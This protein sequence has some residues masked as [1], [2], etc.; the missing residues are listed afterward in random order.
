IS[1]PFQND[2]RSANKQFIAPLP[3]PDASD[4]ERAE[5]ARLARALQQSWTRRRDLMDEAE[6]RLGVLARANHP[7]RWLWPELPELPEMIA[8]APKALK[9]REDR[10]QWAENQLDGL[11]AARIETLQAALASGRR[12]EVRFAGGEL[13]MLADGAPLLRNIFL[14]EDAGRLT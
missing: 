10:R 11:E 12:L 2:Y 9:S 6:R 3:V 5:V 8:N 14:S 1:K 4:S 13:Q 7:A